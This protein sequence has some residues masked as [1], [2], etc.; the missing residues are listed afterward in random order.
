MKLCYFWSRSNLFR[1]NFF[2]FSYRYET[3][4]VNCM[5]HWA[6]SK[7][8]KMEPSGCY[9]STQRS[10][11]QDWATATVKQ[12]TTEDWFST[13]LYNFRQHFTAPFPL[14]TLNLAVV[15]LLLRRADSVSDHHTFDHLQSWTSNNRPRWGE[16]INFIRSKNYRTN[17]TMP[18]LVNFVIWTDLTDLHTRSWMR[19]KEWCRCLQRGKGNREERE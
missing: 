8:T 18:S 13:V 11:E 2:P 1:D 3:S 9:H 6:I 14:I 12:N 15:E 17:R 5:H 16:L 4:I 19:T 10:S 7:L